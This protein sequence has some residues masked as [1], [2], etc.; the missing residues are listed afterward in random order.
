[1]GY[2]YMAQ[3]ML[4]ERK[5]LGLAAFDQHALR[6]RGVMELAWAG[7]DYDEIASYSGHATKAMSRK[8]AGEA[9]QIMRA[10]QAA[11]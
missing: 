1:M 11:A 10:R 2:Y 5:R 9:R 4:R 6:Y 7:C 3:L 8:Y